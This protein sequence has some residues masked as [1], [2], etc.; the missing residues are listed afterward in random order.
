[1]GIDDQ[2]WSDRVACM[3]LAAGMDY[4]DQ[5]DGPWGAEANAQY[6]LGG[7]ALARYDVSARGWLRSAVD[8]EHPGAAFRMALWAFRED[9][10]DVGEAWLARAADLGHGDA[11]NLIEM[12]DHC[13][14][15]CIR[16][17][18]L[19]DFLMAAVDEDCQD[20]AFAPEVARLFART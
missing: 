19:A 12:H 11:L 5:P 20:P 9:Y 4:W 16:G 6:R 18:R 17:P 2:A 3:A 10:Q 1:M 15:A 14:Y 8:D 13:E 7:A